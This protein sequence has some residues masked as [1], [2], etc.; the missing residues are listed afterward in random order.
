MPA[1]S[2][3]A[4]HSAAHESAG[5]QR[6][7]SLFGGA[8]GKKKAGGLAGLSSQM[9]SQAQKSLGLKGEAET[10]NRS[11]L[12][13]HSSLAASLGKGGSRAARDV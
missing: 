8:G 12:L 5:S 10:A 4:V 2:T 1:Q 6:A 7:S 9:R 11:K 13:S 3:N